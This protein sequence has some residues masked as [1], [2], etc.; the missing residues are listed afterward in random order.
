MASNRSRH[1]PLPK[2]PPAKSAVFRAFQ[3]N[4]TALL[5]IGALFL[6]TLLTWGLAEYSTLTFQSKIEG[7]LRS[8]VASDL[9]VSSR[10]FPDQETRTALREV[11]KKYNAKVSESIEFPYTLDLNTSKTATG[12][13]FLTTEVRILDT[14]YPLYGTLTQSGSWSS[15]AVVESTLYPILSGSGFT[16]AD[17]KVPVTGSLIQAP[18]VTQNPFMP[19]QTILIPEKYLPFETITATGAGFRIDYEMDFAVAPESKKA[20][21]DEL[22]KEFGA[23]AN[24]SFRVREQRTDGG[25]LTEIANT[26]NDFL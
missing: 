21:L 24:P 9:S 10:I 19:N 7:E 3:L 14:N 16:I 12:S 5:S 13:R 15:G 2:A 11:A 26:L 25:N 23:E 4:Y 6:I 22:E 17:K 1:L 8:V 18:G 20:L